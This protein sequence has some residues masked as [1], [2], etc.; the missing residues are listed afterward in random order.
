MTP[1]S[2]DPRERVPGA[3]GAVL[4]LMGL[5]LLE[6]LL[7]ELMGAQADWLGLDEMGSSG[8]V[9]LLA[10][11]IVFT[12]LLEYKRLSYG[13]LFHTGP[14]SAQ[15]TLMLTGLPVLML[16]PG[17][18]M[19]VAMLMSVLT[20][21]F[22]MSPSELAMFE[23]MGSGSAAAL[24]T[25]CVLAP[26]LEEMLF[27]GLI[28][29]S[30]LAQYPPHQAILGS[31]LLFGAAHLNIYQG[32][33]G[34]LLGLL[35]GWLYLRSRSLWPGVLLHMAY[36][37]LISVMSR[38]AEAASAD[39][40]LANANPDADFPVLGAMLAVGMLVIGLRILNKL[41]PPAP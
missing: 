19:V 16:V 25:T 4:L 22:P 28:L 32:V 27:R 7:A 39:G 10:H 15:A 23:E 36:N 11:A 38:G 30:F 9:L 12:A 21:L 41:L 2:A 26:V 29:R 34:L 6:M 17:L 24:I 5:M 1:Q 35:T 18:L 40:S 3:M 14:Q 31:A 37:S 8:M 20:V 13:S 33:V